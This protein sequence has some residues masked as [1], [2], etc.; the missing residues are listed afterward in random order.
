MIHN[1]NT[2]HMTQNDR[3]LKRKVRDE[4]NVEVESSKAELRINGPSFVQTYAERPLPLPYAQW[5]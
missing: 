2:C 4:G 5:V 1:H 3:R